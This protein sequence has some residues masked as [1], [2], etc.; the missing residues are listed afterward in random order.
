[1]SSQTWHYLQLIRLP[2]I[3]T[4]PSNVIVGYLALQNGFSGQLVGLISASVLLYVSG[5]VFNDFFDFEHD[6]RNRPMRPLPSGKITKDR[7]LALGITSMI[8]GNLVALVAAGFLGFIVTLVLSA[9]ILAYDYRLKSKSVAGTIA[10]SGAR[11][12]N[13]VLGAAPGLLV[14]VSALSD[15]ALADGRLQTL[16]IAASSMFFYIVSVMIL[17]RTEEE[18]ASRPRIQISMGIFMALVAYIA[19]SGYMVGWDYR[20]FLPL[21]ALAIAIAFTFT[22]YRMQSA[23]STQKI[24]RNMIL[25]IIVLDSVFITANSGVAYGAAILLLL[26]PA[27]LLGKKMYVT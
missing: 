5:I 12:L 20:Y 2:N 26:I 3:F 7:A 27:V 11:G 8:A 15:E 9:I 18:G 13:V 23:A 21:A 24:I 6:R 25:S 14:M 1:M 4:V 19:F 16:L 22:R 17:S 10:M